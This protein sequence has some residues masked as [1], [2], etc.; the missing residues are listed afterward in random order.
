MKN[1]RQLLAIVILGAAAWSCE[2]EPECGEDF[3]GKLGETC[4]RVSSPRSESD[5]ETYEEIFIDFRVAGGVGTLFIQDLDGLIEKG[6][7]TEEDGAYYKDVSPYVIEVNITRLNRNEDGGK[8]WGNFHVRGQ[9]QGTAYE[10]TGSF[11]EVIF[12][13]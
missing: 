6:T 4:A 12:Y 10:L 5:G 3:N 7:Y 13:N 11:N 8:I 9:Y 2:K 1:L